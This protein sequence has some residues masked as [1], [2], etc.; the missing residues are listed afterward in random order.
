MPRRDINWMHFPGS[1]VTNKLLTRI[2]LKMS[3]IIQ[4]DAVALGRQKDSV[5]MDTFDYV[6]VDL[7]GRRTL[8]VLNTIEQC[9]MEMYNTQMATMK[10][11][12]GYMT[13]VLHQYPEGQSS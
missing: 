2:Q 3:T 11:Q 5:D 1:F 6:G 4:D 8:G 10:S 12:W 7:D 13:R 9:P